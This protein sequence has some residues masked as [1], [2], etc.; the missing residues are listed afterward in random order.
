MKKL[1]A[2][3]L[4]ATLAI[5]SVF[6]VA[7]PAFAQEKV[8][9]QD[10]FYTATNNE[11]FE[12]TKIPE[13]YS[14]WGNFDSLN[15]QVSDDLRNIVEEY[16]KK[17]DL[18]DN[19]DEKKLV[20]LYNSFL[21]YKSRDEQGI[22]PI[23]EDLEKIEKASNLKELQSLMVE[24][25]RKGNTNVLSYMVDSDLKDSS[26][27]IL[28]LDTGSIGM[29]DV[30]YYL[31]SDESTKDI[32]KSY[33]QYLTQLF[34]LKGDK[35]EIALKKAENVYNYEK[36]L[37]SVMLSTEESRDYEKLYNVYT[38][39]ALKKLC[40]NLNW[41]DTFSV[42]GLEKA[43]KIVLAQPKYLKKL[44]T[45]L[46]EKNLELYKNYL[47][48]IVLRDSAPF[49]SRDFEKAVFEYSKVFSGVETMR[50]DEERAFDLVNESLGEVLGKIY[51]DKYFSKEAK[52]DVESIVKGLIDSYEKR[53]NKIDWMSKATKQKAIKKLETMTIKI[54]YPNKWEDYSSIKIDSY[55]NGGSLLGNIKNI[56]EYARIKML[57]DWEKPLDKEKWEMTPQTI[58]AYYNPI[59]NEI[60]FPAAILQDPFYK[61]GAST[62]TNLGGIGMVIGH[63]I[64]HAFDDQGSKFDENGNM[65]NWWTSEDL[66]KYESKTKKLASQYSK[67]EVLPNTF[68]NGNL[69]LGENIADLGGALSALETLKAT[70]NP[71]YDEFFKSFS[72]VWRSLDTEETSRYLIKV[73]PHSPG[74]FRVN[75]I[76]TNIDE[77]Y[78]V[79]GVKEGDLMY[80][81]PE[82]RIVIW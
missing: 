21:D 77:F 16:R 49:L 69:T 10:D 54:G 36:E 13:G 11:W 9:L 35:K 61:Y 5:G 70:K 72:K 31:K 62:A 56:D 19:S 17:T 79:Y 7:E 27:K 64:S 18:K 74:K 4:S 39:E 37:A 34:I 76:L 57:R 42:L 29:E 14:S 68:L 12:S 65:V 55:K 40:P 75:G 51:V 81:K 6:P 30:D 15:K 80:T 50:P 43:K 20:D 59:I 73:D 71:N 22:A 63:E 41:N 28:Y 53:I 58:N 82:D 1:Y 67:Y 38:I 26:K 2:L 25:C 66:K 3:L 52:S 33:K 78:E 60:V 24:L 8:R 44:N 45:L 46:E 32:Q 23:K 47:E 48:A